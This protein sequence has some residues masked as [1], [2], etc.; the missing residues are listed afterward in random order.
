MGDVLQDNGSG[1]LSRR[2]ALKAGVGVGVGVVAWSGPTITSLGATPAYAA[3]CTFVV[4]IDL[5]GGC[6]NT[7]QRSCAAFGYHPLKDTGLPSGYSLTNNVPEGTCCTENW[8]PVLHFPDGMQC[9]VTLEFSLPPNCTGTVQKSKVIG[10]ET[11]GAI[12]I[13]LSCYDEIGPVT[14]EFPSQTQY[15]ITAKCNTEG[16]APECIT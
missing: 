2:A 16:A 9:A 11:D 8:T 14:G 6:R 10:P 5:S 7:D 13:P 4:N 12:N 15:M 1:G 3:G